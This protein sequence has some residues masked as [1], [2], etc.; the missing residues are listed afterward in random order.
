MT[1]PLKLLPHGTLF[2]GTFITPGDAADAYIS[3]D[4]AGQFQARYDVAKALRFNCVQDLGQ[5]QEIG[6]SLS[7]STYLAARK[8]NL[9]GSRRTGLY[10]IPIGSI[11]PLYWGS[12][13]LSDAITYLLADALQAST[14]SHVPFYCIIDEGIQQ[15]YVTECHAAYTALKPWMPPNFPIVCSSFFVQGSNTE[16]T[17]VVAHAA[18][19]DCFLWNLNPGT[20][21]GSQWDS[22]LGSCPE[23]EHVFNVGY[24]LGGGDDGFTTNFA[25]QNIIGGAHKVRGECVFTQ[26][27]FLG[28]GTYGLSTGINTGFKAARRDAVQ[29]AWGSNPIIP[30]RR[31]FPGSP[32]INE[33]LQWDYR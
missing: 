7:L 28:G 20:P 22:M 24:A 30:A 33:R 26:E 31:A 11:S 32:S 19:C 16:W 8:N 5:I 12:M 21:T 14:F 15:G 27:D 9:V 4:Y 23:H 10:H 3:Y 29:A 18:Y 2:K 1:T 13:T 17:D 25:A 6:G